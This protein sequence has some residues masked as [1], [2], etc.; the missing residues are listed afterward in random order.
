MQDFEDKD[1]LHFIWISQSKHDG[2]S[3]VF[4]GT[5]QWSSSEAQVVKIGSRPPTMIAA[6]I[7]T[8]SGFVI[9]GHRR[10]VVTLQDTRNK[11]TEF[12]KFAPKNYSNVEASSKNRRILQACGPGTGFNLKQKS[13]I[14]D[15]TYTL[16]GPE[17]V[18]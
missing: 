4:Y 5:F 12:L 16:G 10:G 8:G 14:P 6:T 17:Q 15:I 1:L 11:P 13:P 3:S 18:F 9:D 7:F 2:E